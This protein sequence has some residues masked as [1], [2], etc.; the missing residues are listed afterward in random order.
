MGIAAR[1]TVHVHRPP[2]VTMLMLNSPSVS[3]DFTAGGLY[4]LMERAV[5]PAGLQ[6]I[7]SV[8]LIEPTVLKPMAY[9]WSTPFA[10]V[11]PVIVKMRLPVATSLTQLID[12]DGVSCRDVV[13]VGVGAGVAGGAGVTMGAGVGE[14]G[15]IGAGNGICKLPLSAPW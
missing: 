15:V 13:V 7:V 12:S 9:H 1:P 4:P 14:A 2:L 3:G 8:P 11:T 5:T 10:A 6:R